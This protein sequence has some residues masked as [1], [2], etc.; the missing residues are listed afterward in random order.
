LQGKY[1][2]KKEN[3]I[4]EVIE[5]SLCLVEP[6]VGSALEKTKEEQRDKNHRETC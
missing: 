5:E 6:K 2:G 3:L 4:E 1:N